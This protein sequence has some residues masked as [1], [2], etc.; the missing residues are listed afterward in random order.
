[1]EVGF[2][3]RERACV[4]VARSDEAE[5]VRVEDPLFFEVQPA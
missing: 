1:M 5:L 4:C 2:A 3:V